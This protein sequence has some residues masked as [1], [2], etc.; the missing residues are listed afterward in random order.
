M[1]ENSNKSVLIKDFFKRNVL[2][3]EIDEVLRFK[4]DTLIGIDKISSDHLVS[5]G[6]INIQELAKLSVASLPVIKEILPQMLQMIFKTQLMLQQPATQ[7]SWL[8]DN[9]QETL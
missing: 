4:P 9:T 5:E 6:I 7:S 1:S 2:I 3:N 8:M